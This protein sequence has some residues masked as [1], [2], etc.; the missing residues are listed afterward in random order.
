[1]VIADCTVLKFFQFLLDMGFW[2]WYECSSTDRVATAPG[3][4]SPNSPPPSFREEVRIITAD[5]PVTTPE[6][7][8]I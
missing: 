3:V 4:A 8:S 6:I 1:M 5:T 2:F 7:P